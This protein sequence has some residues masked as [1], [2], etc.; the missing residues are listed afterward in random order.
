MN[1]TASETGVV[2]VP[3]FSVVITSYRSLAYL[4]D[5]LGSVLKSTGPTFEVVFLDNGSPEPEAE[6]IEANI[7]DPRLR[8]FKGEETRY[9][10]GG[11]NFLAARARGE[12]LVWLNS[13]V[14]VEPDWLEKLDAY[15]RRSGFEAAQADVR[16]ARRPERPEIEGYILDRLGLVMDAKGG[17]PVTGRVFAAAGAAYAVRR[18]LFEKLGGLDETFRMYFEDTDFSW[19]MNLYGY[20]I[21]YVRGALVYHV[22][23]GSDRKKFFPWNHFRNTR[24]RMLSFVKNAGLP[25]LLFFIPATLLTRLASI[26]ACLI[27]GRLGDA[28]GEAAAIGS[29]V[30]LLGPALAKRKVVQA[31]RRLSD[32]DLLNQG[33]MRARFKYFS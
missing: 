6:W 31:Q 26:L 21:G 7:R 30:L 27:R 11:V 8:L 13:D 23:H 3:R 29:F 4:P 22:G 19:R 5:C 20:R 25:L 18:D 1:A 28:V 12:F 15:L 17:D 9:F 16:E 10:A 14:K 33:L 24:N 32:R 2:A